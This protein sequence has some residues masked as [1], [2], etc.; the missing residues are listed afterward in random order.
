V[1]GGTAQKDKMEAG[2]G[3]DT[4]WGDIGNDVLEGG[5]GDDS[6]IGGAGND[7]LTDREGDD[8][9]KG[10]D[11][12]D[13]LFAGP[14]EDLLVGGD[15]NDL[16]SGGADED[17]V[18]GGLGNDL[19]LGGAGNDDLRGN[20]GNDVLTG[21]QGDDLLIGDNGNPFGPP[22]PDTDTAV[23]TGRSRNYTITNNAD[24]TITVSDN[25]GNDGTDT[26]VHVE[27]LQFLDR[28]IE[29]QE[30]T[31]ALS[32]ETSVNNLGAGAAEAIE[33][34]D[35]AVAIRKLQDISSLLPSDWDVV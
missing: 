6:I 25:V 27:R 17:E 3:N 26:L 34:G 28:L 12:K 30:P 11:G 24:G 14:G 8:F 9:L 4:L 2:G 5:A 33:R 7:I 23:L 32:D 20:E 35:D 18:F 31:G 16:I 10:G 21:G 1:L 19:I 13:A 29:L 15:G 22:L